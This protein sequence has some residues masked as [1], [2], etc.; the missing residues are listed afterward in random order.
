MARQ[1]N[2]SYQQPANTAA[3]S[4][5][6]ISSTAYNTLI[7]DIG[8][9][10][11]NSLDRGGRSA[12]TANLPMGGNRATGAA[13]PVNAQ[14]FAT[15][16]YTDTAVAS[17]FST[18]DGK[19]TLKNV[20]DPGWVMSNDGTIGSLA[21]GASTR[22]NADTQALFTLLFNN[23]SDT[24]APIFTSGGGA[25]TRAAQTNA[26]SAWAAN[27]RMSLTKVLGRALASA[28]S[29]GG[30]AGTWSLGQNYGEEVHTL[31]TTEMPAHRHSVFISDPGHTH[32]SNAPATAFNF[33][34][35]GGVPAVNGGA[36]AVINGATTGISITSGDGFSN[37][38]LSAGG[39]AAHNIMQPTS[40]WNV[41]VKL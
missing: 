34:Q 28:G 26:S 19:I 11:T 16:N 23:I 7:T 30:P 24:Y 13:D 36:S 3:V 41:M 25:T 40:F 21:S 1:A 6:T 17:F 9:E 31:S 37:V 35:S 27:C 20:A 15:K 5:Q 4:G 12:M 29:S 32:T 22:A 18:G 39:G 2:G 38:T 8:T 10:L 33:F 14:D